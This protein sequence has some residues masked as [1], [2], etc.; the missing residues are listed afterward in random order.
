MRRAL[1]L[2][3][4]LLLPPFGE[5]PPDDWHL[6]QRS[7]E[8]HSWIRCRIYQSEMINTIDNSTVGDVH[9]RRLLS[10]QLRQAKCVWAGDR[11]LR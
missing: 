2:G 7:H 1:L 9:G 10:T 8:F 3:W 6:W 5:P 11:R 4:I